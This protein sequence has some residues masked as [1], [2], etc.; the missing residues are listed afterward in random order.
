MTKVTEGATAPIVYPGAPEATSFDEP[1]AGNVALV[2]FSR[3]GRRPRIER[4]RVA[5]WTWR[6]E[7]VQSMLQGY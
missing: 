1:G 2:W 6:Q 5:R 3:H 7:T 4:E